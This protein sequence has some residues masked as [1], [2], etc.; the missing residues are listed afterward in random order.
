L[1][2]IPLETA[3]VTDLQVAPDGRYAAVVD[4]S[5][6]VTVCDLQDSVVRQFRTQSS[7]ASITFSDDSQCIVSGGFNG[8]L[9]I[10]SVAPHGMATPVTHELGAPVLDLVARPNSPEVI[11]ATSHH[12]RVI[13]P[14]EPL[15]YSRLPLSGE[16]FSARCG[17]FHPAA[18][19]Y[20]CH[21]GSELL[22]FDLNGTNPEPILSA[23]T[24]N[25]RELEVSDHLVA[26]TDFRG[27]LSLWDARTAA[28]LS[29]NGTAP[30]KAIALH[31]EQPL[32]AIAHE[33]HSV[34]I[35]SLA[36]GVV[37]STATLTIRADELCFPRTPE[38][39][40]TLIVL[41]PAEG[42]SLTRR[43]VRYNLGS[44]EPAASV[45]VSAPRSPG[46][47]VVHP[48]FPEQALLIGS[49]LRLSVCGLKPASDLR[50]KTGQGF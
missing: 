44:D 4:T 28:P 39:E 31:P 42:P 36:N 17:T 5:G 1:L 18:H 25:I 15:N 23:S 13:N 48:R 8:R 33:D 29:W 16:P 35:F 20:A 27:Q 45:D 49:G 50:V 47:L 26:G 14:G 3:G 12:L 22:L 41:T 10:I 40:G 11:A 19:T 21:T 6:T 37:E 46:R 2:S 7:A 34:E 38:S 9:S 24:S 30:V 43:V 32:F